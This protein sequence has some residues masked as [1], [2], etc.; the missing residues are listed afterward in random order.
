[1]RQAGVPIALGTDERNTDDTVNL[2]GV[3]KAAGLIHKIA[4]RD[5]R[6][7]PTATE[8]LDCAIHGGARGMGLE[9]MIGAVEVGRRADLILVD[10]D[11]LAFTPLNNLERQLVFCEN[12]SSVR[13]VMVDGRIVVEDGELTTI[14]E[15]ALRAEVRELAAEFQSGFAATADAAARLEPYYR[16]AVLRSAD[17]DVGMQRRAGP[18]RP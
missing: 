4:E 9:G 5:Y 17:A 10:L 15:K 6:D 3:M 16:E 2:W 12:G 18:M 8:V 1:L 11:T 14:D 7:W 13:M